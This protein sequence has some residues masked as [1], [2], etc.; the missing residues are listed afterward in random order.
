MFLAFLQ[1]SLFI[2]C[3]LEELKIFIVL[4]ISIYTFYSALFQF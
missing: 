4:L 3:F 2:D 1:Q